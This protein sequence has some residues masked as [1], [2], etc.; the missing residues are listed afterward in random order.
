MEGLGLLIAFLFFI[1][2]GPP[3]IFFIVGFIMHSRKKESAKILFILGAVWLLVGAGTCL[4]M[5]M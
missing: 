1:A 3:I 4:S 2:F 5:L